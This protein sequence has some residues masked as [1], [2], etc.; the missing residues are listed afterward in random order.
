MDEVWRGNL[1]AVCLVLDP[2]FHDAVEVTFTH[3]DTPKCP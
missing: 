2:V 1:L 3:L